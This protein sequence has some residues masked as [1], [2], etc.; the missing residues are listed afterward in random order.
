MRLVSAYRN[1][2]HSYS[3]GCCRFDPNSIIHPQPGCRG[4]CTNRFLFCLWPFHY[5][6]PDGLG[7]SCPNGQVETGVVGGD[8]LTFTGDSLG[9]SPNPVVFT[10]PGEWP[11]SERESGLWGSWVL[12]L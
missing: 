10:V 6:S 11:V 9:G 1:E 12:I 8:N 7:A 2:L 3:R 4:D 5:F